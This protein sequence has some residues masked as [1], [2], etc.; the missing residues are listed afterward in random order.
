MLVSELIGHEAL[1]EGVLEVTA[2]DVKRLLTP[3][4]RL[5]PGRVALWGLPV[6]IPDAE[7][8][9][10]TVTAETRQN[11]RSWYGIDFGPL[12][13]AARG[14]PYA[15]LVPPHKARGWTALSAPV[16]LADLDLKAVGGAAI[17]RAVGVTATM[18][19]RLNGLL[20]YFELELGPATRLST[21][22]AEA[23]RDNHWGS[24]VWVLDDPLPVRPGDRLEVAYGYRAAGGQSTVRVSRA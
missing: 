15:F 14:A 2:D 20:V 10:R 3:E 24:P 22:P 7:L 16:L 5:V 21:H 23:G 8:R 9:R 13:A 1:D 19:G 12:A 11:W 18:S 6:N 4:A 17:E